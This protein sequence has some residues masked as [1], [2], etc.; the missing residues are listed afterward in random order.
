MKAS[1]RLAL[2]AVAALG[3]V[4]A[5]TAGA[6]GI[7]DATWTAPTT[8]VDGSPLTDLSGYRVFFS[9]TV[10]PPCSGAT[11]ATIASPTSS[12][13]P[14]ERISVRLQG[15]TSGT[16]YHVAVTALNAAGA[17]SSCSVSAS[18]TAHADFV[19]NPT[20]TVDFGTVEVGES[21]DRSFDVTNT[22]GGTV[23]GTVSVPAPFSVVAGSPFSLEGQNASQ[24]VTVRFTPD[25]VATV[26]ASAS[27]AVGGDTQSRIV[28]GTATASTTRTADTTPPSVTVSAPSDGATLSRT[29]VISAQASD[30]VGVVG[31]Q[32]VVDGVGV[33]GEIATAPYSISWNT[34]TA[35]D[36]PHTLVAVARDAAG[37]VASSVPLSVTTANGGNRKGGGGS[38]GA[39]GGAG[40]GG[41]KNH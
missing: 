19:V 7:L 34:R 13:A 9:S 23:S 33:G 4:L 11:S 27:F 10:D 2:V 22:V 24:T 12:P 1:L 38:G 30:D 26:S 3:A 32:F 5:P 31:V 40:G 25:T 20:A 15:L 17:E 8:N 6:A 14:N 18:A 39:G 21:V 28:T 35:V 16:L 36:G 37:N 41:K 29:V